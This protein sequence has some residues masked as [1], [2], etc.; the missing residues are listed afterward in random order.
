MAL[1]VLMI[2]TGIPVSVW[3]SEGDAVINTAFQLLFAQDH[4]IENPDALDLDN[5]MQMKQMGLL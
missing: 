4:D 5:P 2:R 3:E 1:T